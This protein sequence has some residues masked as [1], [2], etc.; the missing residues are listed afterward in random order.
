MLPGME[1]LWSK[2]RMKVSGLAAL[3][4]NGNTRGLRRFL[5][6]KL[7]TMGKYKRRMKVIFWKPRFRLP[8]SIK[9][10]ICRSIERNYVGNK[11]L[12]FYIHFDVMRPRAGWYA[13]Y[14]ETWQCRRTYPYRESI[15][16][17]R[18]RFVVQILSRW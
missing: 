10:E 7:M 16:K 12:G 6:L 2:N 1:R 17:R 13:G 18:K 8:Q 3:A 14:V 4:Q 5:F 9:K 11:G 15:G